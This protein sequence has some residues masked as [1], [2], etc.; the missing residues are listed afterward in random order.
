M[1]KM[2][3][4]TVAEDVVIDRERNTLSLFNVL[5]NSNYPGFPFLFQRL[6]VLAITERDVNC[7]PNEIDLR[8][9]ISMANGKVLSETIKKISYQEESSNRLMLRING[10]LIPTKGTVKFTIYHARKRLG[11]Y[12]IDVDYLDEPEIKVA[13]AAVKKNRRKKSKKK[14]SKKTR[15]K[16][17]K[18]TKKKTMKKTTL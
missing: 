14:I 17:T 4:I 15:K 10:L 13:S 2:K 12:S 7:D 3:L 9:R 16:T 11:L 5:E 6:V 8:L 18:K 1:I